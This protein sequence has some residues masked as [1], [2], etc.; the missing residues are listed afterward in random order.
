MSINAV[1]I[2]RGNSIFLKN[3]GENTPAIVASFI[4]N[5]MSYGYA[6]NREAM[7]ALY[8][9]DVETLN[10]IIVT[11]RD[12][13]GWK[14]GSVKPMYPN[15]PK[16]V[17]EASDAELYLNSFLHYFG[18]VVGVRIMPEYFVEARP[19][20]KQVDKV[21]VL[22]LYNEDDLVE[23]FGSI[24]G[25]SQ[26][27]S[28]QDKDDLLVLRDY[29]S[30]GALVTVKE[31]VAWL[32]GEFPDVD[33]SKNV[34]TVTDV[35]R[36]AV[37]ISGG[38]TSL[39]E[40]T[41]F[42]LNRKQR[43]VVLF[44]L[45]N[46]LKSSGSVND[47]FL[48][49]S[50]KWKRLAHALRADDYAA[51]Y[52]LSVSMLGKVQNGEIDKGY[53]SALEGAL[54]EREFAD[55]IDLLVQRPGVFARRLN[56][57]VRKFPKSRSE[58]LAHFNNVADRV[59]SNVLVQL[60]N[61][62]NG[63]DD[64]VNPQSVVS[65]KKGNHQVTKMIGNRLAAGD[66]SDIIDVIVSGISRKNDGRKIFF[67]EDAS[68]YAVPL[69]VRSLSNASKQIARGSRV[70]VTDEDKDKSIV[71]FFMYWNESGG[72]SGRVDLDL[73]AFFVSEDFSKVDTIAYYGLRN[74]FARHSGDV[75]SAP[76]GASEFIDIEIDG[77]LKAGYRYLVPSVYN[78]TRQPFSVVPEA[79]SGYMMRE[80][81]NSGEIF[82]PTTVRASYT[83]DKNVSNSVPFVFDLLKRELI[84][85]DYTI[86]PTVGHNYN[87]ENNES[88]FIVLLK[89]LVFS[90]DMTMSQFGSLVGVVVDSAD[91][92]DV[93]VD[94]SRFE[95]C[96]SIVSE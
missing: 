42:S 29:V 5:A 36:V 38:D 96:G 53:N 89:D 25:M 39:S 76:N 79:F 81:M 68:N 62:Y 55:V 43:R 80:D 64:S 13:K 59:S 88:K 75:T 73:S 93:I 70:K 30:S 51:R 91:D 19:V 92:A 24:I 28:R 61:F 90:N 21:T 4:A 31:N 9:A 71:R 74:G 23:K 35:L 65:I 54:R 49:F 85:W 67:T 3:D 32:V 46:V 12:L 48:K 83:L 58:V 2:R 69:G 87:V 20:L 47:D 82:E 17:M 18:D 86:P 78:Y 52:P 95:D 94:P 63:A 41:K 44:L 6:F 15:F 66:N 14:A 26:P 84:W 16:Q 40:N 34:R 72:H 33:W 57:V 77:A 8:G 27:F 10:D 56:E 22:G 37:G 60:Y 45:E 11:M 50:E 7:N 1:T